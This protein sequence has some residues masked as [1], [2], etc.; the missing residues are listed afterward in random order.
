MVRSLAR[1][2]ATNTRARN[3]ESSVL[4][5]NRPTRSTCKKRCC[6]SQEFATR[7]GSEAYRRCSMSELRQSRQIVERDSEKKIVFSRFSTQWRFFGEY[8]P[9]GHPNGKRQ[10]QAKRFVKGLILTL[11]F[12][13]SSHDVALMSLKMSKA[14]YETR[15]E[16]LGLLV[17]CLFLIDWPRFL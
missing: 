10:N 16:C 17:D 5:P 3:R 15:G 14:V 7:G 4:P 13:R 9:Q 8:I 1:R 6:S 2:V 12:A 11:E